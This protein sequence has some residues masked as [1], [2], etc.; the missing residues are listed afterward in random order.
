MARTSSIAKDNKKPKFSS[1]QH[2]RCKLCGR[3]RAY[4]A[5]V[6]PLPAVLP[7]TGAAGRDSWGIEVVLVGRRAAAGAGRAMALQRLTPEADPEARGRSPQRL[8]RGPQTGPSCASRNKTSPQVL[9]AVASENGGQPV[10][11]GA[12]LRTASARKKENG[13]TNSGDGTMSFTDPV[14]DFLTRIRNGIKARHQKVDAPASK[15]KLE[16]ATG[17][18]RRRVHR[19]LQGDGRR[20]QESGSG[21][22]QVQ[23]RKCCRDQQH[24]A[25][26]T[27]GLPGVC[28][29]ATRFRGSLGVWESRS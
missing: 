10:Q 24:H 26:F 25:D 18:K 28:R 12:V 3:P 22:H 7:R 16:I 11:A 13:R 14:A 20:R 8:A 1:R 2:N 4:P 15:L 9:S 6:R 27:S 19:Q 5:Q 17:S 23:R 29:T 21:V